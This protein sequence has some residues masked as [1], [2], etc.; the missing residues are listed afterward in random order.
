MRNAVVIPVLCIALLFSSG[1]GVMFQGSNQ[2][3]GIHS[4]PS[5]ATVKGTPGIGEYTTPCSVSLSRKNSYDL[6]FTKEGYKPVSAYINASV[7]F[8]YVLLD[9]LLTGLVGVI[10]DAATGGWNGLK[11]DFISVTLEKED[12]NAIGPENIEVEICSVGSNLLIYS[13]DSPVYVNIEESK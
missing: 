9:V 5:G 1:C 8:G 10:V 3:V 4:S 6:T 13:D 2:T 11:P 12:R 7:K